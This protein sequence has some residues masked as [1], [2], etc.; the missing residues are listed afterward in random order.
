MRW[1]NEKTNGER[2]LFSV[3]PISIVGSI[4]FVESDCKCVEVGDEI[5][6]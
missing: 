1:K 2:D 5:Q 4:V 6:M 3:Y